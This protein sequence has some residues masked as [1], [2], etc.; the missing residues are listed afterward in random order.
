MVAVMAQPVNPFH[1]EETTP[2][3]QWD[4]Y[5]CGERVGT[6]VRFGAIWLTYYQGWEMRFDTMQ[7]ACAYLGGLAA[8]PLPTQ[9][10]VIKK[11]TPEYLYSLDLQHCIT[12]NK[13]C[14]SCPLN[15]L[16]IKGHCA[17]E[18]R[19][20]YYKEKGVEFKSPRIDDD[21]SATGAPEMAEIPLR[22]LSP[23]TGTW[24]K[25]RMGDSV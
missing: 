24:F 5:Y 16:K 7:Q 11:P 9:P 4:V 19:A 10:P 20:D 15:G 14:G 6:I 23:V 8:K 2:N 18:A 21:S 1:L 22:V 17:Y 13:D 12:S 25:F 3:K